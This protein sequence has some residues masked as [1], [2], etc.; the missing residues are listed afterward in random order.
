MALAEQ[1]E[2]LSFG[3]SLPHIESCLG[4][5]LAPEAVFLSEVR[6]DKGRPQVIHLLKL[7]M[8]GGSGRSTKTAATL[9]ADFLNEP[10]KVAAIIAKAL[11]EGSWKSKH[12]MVSLAAEFGI[13]RY[14]TMPAFE[15]RFWKT[16]VPVEAKKYIPI[17]FQTLAAD[18]QVFNVPPGPDKKPRLGALYGVTQKKSLDSLRL[19]VEKLGLILVG[20]ELAPVSVERLWD[21]LSPETAST[22]YAQVHFD[23]GQT[24]I[25]VSD[26]GVPVFYREVLLA[27]DATV[28]D[29]R[30]VDLGGCV[31]FARK[32]LGLADPK[33]ARVSGQ[34]GDIKSWQDAFAQDLGQPVAY[35]DTDKLLGLRGGQWGGYASIG[36]AL[37]H[38][39]PSPLTL[40]LSAIG[41]ISDE[42]RRAATTILAAGAAFAALFLLVGGY[43]MVSLSSQ[44][45]KLRGLQAKTATLPEFKGKNA[46][47]IAKTITEMRSKINS[48]GA[49]TAQQTPL[50]RIFEIVAERIPETAWLT[51]LKYENPLALDGKPQPRVLTLTG[52]VSDK[53]RAIEQEVS[54]RFGD[55][56]RGDKRFTEAFKAVEPSVEAPRADEADAAVKKPTSFII[57][58]ASQKERTGA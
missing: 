44:T 39:T 32:Q 30:K 26:K 8:P 29:R 50:T 4:L 42:D 28:M 49:L 19:M 9:S 7:P 20:T 54:Y 18:Y 52:G 46:D 43:R 5:Y 33:H 48:F 22:S 58:C 1:I 10:D 25:L 24:R 45:S 57:K 40:D 53:S 51:D 23:G 12:V 6:A 55:N 16:A 17:P 27:D 13:L 2:Q 37:R 21:C 38:I 31:D 15:R 47:D 14:F 34:I 41:K 36:S 3:R 35:Q 11:G 56:L